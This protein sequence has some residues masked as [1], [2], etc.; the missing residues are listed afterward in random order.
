LSHPVIIT[1]G[2]VANTF[3]VTATA[4]GEMMATDDRYFG[5]PLVRAEV[6]QDWLIY[7][8]YD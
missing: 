3:G 2:E 1:V 4:G 7:H 6:F 5:A 8:C